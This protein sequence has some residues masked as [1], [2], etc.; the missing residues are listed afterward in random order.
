MTTLAWVVLGGVL[1]LI[2]S[3]I[4]GIKLFKALLLALRHQRS[5]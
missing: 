5:S 2:V 4:A 3:A 1:A